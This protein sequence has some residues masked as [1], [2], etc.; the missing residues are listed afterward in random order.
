[1]HPW[2]PV[3]RSYSAAGTA[4]VRRSEPADDDGALVA[5]F[6]RPEPGRPA[7]S[8]DDPTTSSSVNEPSSS[9]PQ[10]ILAS[11]SSRAHPPAFPTLPE[12]PS[13]DELAYPLT[14][15]GSRQPLPSSSK[16]RWPELDH[17]PGL[18]RPG[19]GSLTDPK[20]SSTVPN[21]ASKGTL[22][23]EELY[24][25]PTLALARRLSTEATSS[26][27]IEYLLEADLQAR[28][29][30]LPLRAELVRACD[31][32]II[33][34]CERHRLKSDG[35]LSGCDDFDLA[36]RE[37]RL[38]MHTM[39]L[40]PPRTLSKDELYPPATLILARRLALEADN[41]ED[42]EKQL[43]ADYQPRL[44][45]ANSNTLQQL[46]D[47][48]KRLSHFTWQRRRSLLKGLS[49]EHDFDV[50]WRAELA[51]SSS[52]SWNSELFPAS[53]LK[54][55]RRL[56]HK[57]SSPK[58]I[59]AAIRADFASRKEAFNGSAAEFGAACDLL[60]SFVCTLREKGRLGTSLSQAA[61]Q[62]AWRHHLDLSK[63]R[64]RRKLTAPEIPK[65][66]S[67]TARPSKTP[68]LVPAAAT[69]STATK[70][71]P[72]I[73]PPATLQSLST[74]ASTA[75]RLGV[76]PA[77]TPLP[78]SEAPKS[79]WRLN[80]PA[81]AGKTTPSTATA[82]HSAA[83]MGPRTRPST[84][85]EKTLA[86]AP[87]AAITPAPAPP[88]PTLESTMSSLQHLI[89]VY[90][91]SLAPFSAV[92]HSPAVLSSGMSFPEALEARQRQAKVQQAKDV[93][94]LTRQALKSMFPDTTAAATSATTAARQLLSPQFATPGLKQ[95]AQLTRSP[96]QAPPS[97]SA[98]APGIIKSPKAKRKKGGAKQAKASPSFGLAQGTSTAG[99]S[100][101]PKRQPEATFKLPTRAS[102]AALVIAP[103]RTTR[104]DPSRKSL[105]AP[106]TSSADAGP[107]QSTTTVELSALSA[108]AG[109]P[110]TSSLS[111][112]AVA[113]S[114]VPVATDSSTAVKSS[115][116]TDSRPV[117]EPLLA[118]EPPSAI[119]PASTS[120]SP[121]TPPQKQQKVLTKKGSA[122]SMTRPL[123]TA[124]PAHRKPS[125]ETVARERSPPPGPPRR[126]L[127]QTFDW[128]RGA[129][130][131]R[132]AVLTDG[133]NV[134]PPRALMTFPKVSPASSQ[135]PVTGAV[136]EAESTLVRE[137]RVALQQHGKSTLSK[138]RKPNT[139]MLAAADAASAIAPSEQSSPGT[140]VIVR[141]Q[142]A[143]A[144]A[145][146]EPLRPSP[147]PPPPVQ[148]AVAEPGPSVPT[149]QTVL[150]A[151]TPHQVYAIE[152]LTRPNLSVT[153]DNGGC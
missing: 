127:T 59:Q 68:T 100:S 52:T 148:L 108:P 71:S 93:L 138:R 83:K 118:S 11:A 119:K 17:L 18:S 139:G 101:A 107:L 32:L 12:S 135:I 43:R 142:I 112:A 5:R 92:P 40:R 137:T 58:D 25:A 97:A 56:F 35:S 132:L 95:N 42:I 105:S 7:A 151:L 48:Y 36:W 14:T 136:P 24:P 116:A 94:E 153:P 44:R 57:A 84:V 144:P 16:L 45:H 115:R 111:E 113:P 89:D 134:A 19:S 87:T 70:R 69:G 41:F 72:P 33:F 99:S 8:G 128:R 98:S 75:P 130:Y 55:A 131:R 9:T 147:P 23:D 103:P 143:R 85:H 77:R 88:M 6:L 31:R 81:A 124:V 125:A 141:S 150:D 109:P 51:K 54:L 117:A 63:G 76:I 120:L 53:T 3:G 61:F 91:S 62:D 126:D 149:G 86:S 80:S 47:A 79:Q 90:S 133:N 73:P 13:P 38:A 26:S 50:A 121:S 21:E 60:K 78:T 29:E 39:P 146:V 114:S 28:R 66:P 140:P 102:D 96:S 67:Q 110:P 27:D 145:I 152:E 20:G 30:G 104:T 15:P 49:L 106:G 4:V 46:S 123:S 22:T 122:P 2:A 64:F 34:T 37:E 74:A 1:M 129:A 10:S 65:P 82:L